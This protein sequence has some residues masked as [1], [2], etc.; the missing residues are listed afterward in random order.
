[1]APPPCG[2][3]EGIASL[4]LAWLLVSGSG[5]AALPLV[6]PHG[7]HA[8]GDASYG[9]FAAFAHAPPPRTA[10]PPQ[11]KHAVRRSALAAAA[12]ATTPPRRRESGMNRPLH[13]IRALVCARAQQSIASEAS[14]ALVLVLRLV[15]VGV[16]DR[17]EEHRLRKCV[18]ALRCVQHAARRHSPHGMHPGL[19]VYLTQGSHA[20]GNRMRVFLGGDAHTLAQSSRRIRVRICTRA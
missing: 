13:R 2:D 18:Q 8:V 7:R 6:A 9:R 16:T 1:M 17:A 20:I 5:A 19:A 4:R 12:S 3:S 14:R 10:L 11:T 15:L